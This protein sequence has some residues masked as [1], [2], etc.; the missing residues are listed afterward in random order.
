MRLVELKPTYHS[1]VL[2]PVGAG[3][4]RIAGSIHER[5]SISRKSFSLECASFR[6][7]F[8]VGGATGYNPEV[9]LCMGKSDVW[10]ISLEDLLLL[11]LLS[12]LLPIVA[13]FKAAFRWSIR[14]GVRVRVLLGD[15]FAD[16][17]E[18][19]T[20]RSGTF[21]TANCL[22]LLESSFFRRSC[23]DAFGRQLSKPEDTRIASK[24]S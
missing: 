15:S 24:R 5:S 14:P 4:L 13:D 7:G 10:N 1:A 9:I 3:V 6:F 18:E 21:P 2:S 16:V 22:D 8:S 23:A 11:S 20:D 17:G 12:D 19:S